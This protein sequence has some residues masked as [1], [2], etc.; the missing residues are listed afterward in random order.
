QGFAEA[1]DMADEVA[2]LPIYPARELPIEGITSDII[3]NAMT[4]Q[5]RQ[6]IAKEQVPGWLLAELKGRGVKGKLV[7]TAGAGDIDT[8]IEPIKELIG[9]L[10]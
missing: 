7:I 4:N 9:T 8:L 5:R 1:L 2:L 6:I 3:F 10:N